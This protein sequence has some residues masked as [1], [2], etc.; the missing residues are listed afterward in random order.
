MDTPTSSMSGLSRIYIIAPVIVLLVLAATALWYLAYRRGDSTAELN[1]SLD[2]ITATTSTSIPS[3]SNSLKAATPAVN[4][5]EK[6]NPF[7]NEYQNPFQ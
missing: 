5:I 4:P 3:T 2:A 7:T 6:T 1:F